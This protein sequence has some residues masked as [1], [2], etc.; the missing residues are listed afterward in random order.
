MAL[1]WP[2]PARYDGTSVIPTRVR[3]A[4]FALLIAPALAVADGQ[5]PPRRSGASL[6]VVRTGG[7]TP[8]ALASAG[9]HEMIALGDLAPLFPIAVREDAA[10]G[11]VTLSCRGRTVAL[12]QGQNVVS[13]AGRLVSLAYP[14]VRDG[15]RWLVPLEFLDKA[16]GPACDTRIDVR[17]RSRLIVIGDARVPRIAVTVDGTAG[18]ARVIFDLTPPTGHTIAQESNRLLVRFDSDAIDVAPSPAAVP[19]LVQAVRVINTANLMAI[20]LGPRF[21]S[22]RTSAQPGEAGGERFVVEIVAAATE[23]PPLGEAAVPP[24]PPPPP[25]PSATPAPAAVLTTVVIDPGHGGDDAGA[26]G[27]AGT[28][29][30]DVTIGV[31]RRLKTAIETRLG[32]RVLLTRNADLAVPPDDRTALANNNQA[33]MFVSLHAN[34]SYK[35]EARGAAVY[36]FD[37]GAEIPDE[38][39]PPGVVLPTLGGGT[40]KIDIVP[41]GLAQ[42]RFVPLS[43]TLATM[44]SEELESRVEVSARPVEQAPLRVLVGANMPAAL[45]EMGFLSNPEQEQ[46]LVSEPYQDQIVQALVEALTRF[47]ASLG[48]EHQPAQPAVAPGT[49]GRLP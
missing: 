20:D 22:Y 11:G 12:T 32:V 39:A 44:I 49:G 14:V 38:S 31:A 47:R 41:W 26:R 10:A 43:A 21:G 17:A 42:L 23:R 36:Y 29:E 24:L 7:L 1:R 2:Q 3:I 15:R 30:K 37:A 18:A 4:T 8:L 25:L 19:G 46:Q 9:D 35:A 6:T 40:R 45:V 16:L 5:S 33:S 13:V 34:M 28:A 27:A 48:Q